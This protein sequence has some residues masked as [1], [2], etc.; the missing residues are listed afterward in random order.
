MTSEVNTLRI[1][2]KELQKHDKEFHKIE[3]FVHWRTTWNTYI[4]LH[5]NDV[6]ILFILSVIETMEQM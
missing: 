5:W 4:I 6:I 2:N 3:R 1:L